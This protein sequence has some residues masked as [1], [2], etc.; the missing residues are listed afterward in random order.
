[1]R[2]EEKKVRSMPRRIVRVRHPHLPQAER[3][4][5]LVAPPAFPNGRAL[6]DERN[7]PLETEQLHR[8]NQAANR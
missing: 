3:F 6:K 1:M 8:A 2:A 5:H 7:A 4:Q